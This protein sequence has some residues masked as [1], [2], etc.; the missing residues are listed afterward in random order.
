MSHDALRRLIEKRW[1]ALHAERTTG[2]H[3]L[4][5]SQL[6]VVA[7]RGPLAVAID[8]DGHR[9]LL[10]PIHTNR[11]LR[12]GLD[13]PVLHLRKRA[14]EDEESYQTYA[15]LA[16]LRNDLSDLFTELCV[17]VLGEAEGLPENPVKALYRVLDRWKAL[18]LAQGPPLGPEQLA[19]LFGE[20]T[21][22]ARLLERDSSAHRLWRGP[23]GHR[24]DFSTGR[25]AVEV[26][27]STISDGRKPR[28]H[29]LDQLDPPEGGSL[30]LA[31]FRLH[32]TDLSGSGMPFL[33]LLNRTLQLCDDEAVLLDLLSSAGYRPSDASRYRD[34]CFVV[35]EE[36]W[37]PVAPG[38]PG[39]TARVLV[40]SGVPISALDVE[41]T[42]DLSGATPAP[43][44]PGLVPQV[45]DNLIQESL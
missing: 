9:H 7:E 18:L 39:L 23:E 4:R 34:V 22:L 44:T 28:I 12:P 25:F 37:Y 29:G 33:D 5:V 42:I 27:S 21:V 11:T 26:K 17:D 6:P 10:V 1:A 40:E 14:L 24:H 3:R 35:R 31:W 8:H 32:R 36:K 30:H 15:D 41:F 20:L 2:E 43:L 45:I 13:G 38:F 19:G 16:C